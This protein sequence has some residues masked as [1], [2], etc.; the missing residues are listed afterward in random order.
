VLFASPACEPDRARL[1]VNGRGTANLVQLPSRWRKRLRAVLHW[2]YFPECARGVAAENQVIWD[3]LSENRA[4]QEVRLDVKTLSALQL[5]H[6][7]QQSGSSRRNLQLEMQEG[8]F[9]TL[10]VPSVSF[11]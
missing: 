2:G 9:E 1:S 11:A 8:S 3:N 7:L 4:V 6:C 5:A 10:P